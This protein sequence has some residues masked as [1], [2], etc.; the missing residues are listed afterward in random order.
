MIYIKLIKKNSKVG[1][2]KMNFILLLV[3]TDFINLNIST[4]KLVQIMSYLA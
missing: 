1:S 3:L 2:F 4:P